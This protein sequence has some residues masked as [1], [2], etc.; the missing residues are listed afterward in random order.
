MNNRLSEKSSPRLELFEDQE[1][2]VRMKFQF[3][4]GG[5]P[6]GNGRV[7]PP[8]VLKKAVGEF[9]TRLNTGRS[10]Y[11]SAGHKRGGMEVPD[12]SHQIEGLEMDKDNRVWAKVK[13]LPTAA[14]KDLLAILKNGGKLGVSARGV[15]EVRKNDKGLDEVTD[16]YRLDGCDFVL[17]PSTGSFVGEECFESAEVSPEVDEVLREKYVE[18]CRLANYKGTYEE[19]RRVMGPRVHL[20]EDISSPVASL[21]GLE[22]P[23]LETT[24]AADIVEAV[25]AKYGSRYRVMESFEDGAVL[26]DIDTSEFCWVEAT[27]D[28]AGRLVVSEIKKGDD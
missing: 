7:Y 26:F 25:R 2:V 3:L 24:P 1:G 16:S 27:R 12:V 13:V 14:G 6:T 5:I 23:E 20:T 8:Q 9:S 22:A 17:D 18:A 4:Q 10:L 21:P 19:Y 28:S 11:G 15:G